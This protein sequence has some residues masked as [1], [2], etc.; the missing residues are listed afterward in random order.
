MQAM[1]G[2]YDL[3]QLILQVCCTMVQQHQTRASGRSGSRTSCWSLPSQPMP[4]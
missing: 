2:V 1:T 4:H 3:V